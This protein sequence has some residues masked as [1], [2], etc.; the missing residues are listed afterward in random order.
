[1]LEM[2]GKMFKNLFKNKKKTKKSLFKDSYNY[3]RNEYTLIFNLKRIQRDFNKKMN[4][5]DTEKDDDFLIPLRVYSL[6]YFLQEYRNTNTEIK[7]LQKTRGS[8]LFFASLFSILFGVFSMFNTVAVLSLFPKVDIP[9]GIALSCISV[10]SVIFW[11][12]FASKKV[13]IIS[14]IDKE[15]TDF[16]DFESTE[17]LYYK[18]VVTRKNF[19]L[20]NYSK[21]INELYVTENKIRYPLTYLNNKFNYQDVWVVLKQ[22]DEFIERNPNESF[23][24]YLKTKLDDILIYQEGKEFYYKIW[25]LEYININTI[26]NK[27]TSDYQKVFKNYTSNNQQQLLLD[28]EKLKTSNEK[29]NVSKNYSNLLE[30][31]LYTLDEKGLA[32]FGTH[33]VFFE[34]LINYILNRKDYSTK[35]NYKEMSKIYDDKEFLAYVDSNLNLFIKEINST[36]S[37]AYKKGNKLQVNPKSVSSFKSTPQQKNKIDEE[38]ALEMKSKLGVLKEVIPKY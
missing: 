7:K 4:R 17:G 14:G 3:R 25:L 1:M 29:I 34:I 23:A 31:N 8:K 36:F 28:C 15:G 32:V 11:E 33:S 18:E 10:S 6:P 37:T 21:E 22:I 38:T 27:R 9:I 19:Y 2:S 24:K 20:L 35:Y 12:Y 5:N 30:K 26:P 13:A 16:D